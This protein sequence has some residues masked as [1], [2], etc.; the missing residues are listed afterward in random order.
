M[1]DLK[2]K[3]DYVDIN[4]ISGY[5]NNSRTHSEEQIR[6]IENS[7]KEFGMCNPIGVCNGVIVFGHGRYKA[8]GNL[9]YDEIPVIDLSHLNGEQMKALVIA[10]NKIGDNSSFDYDILKIE[11]EELADADFDLSLTGFNDIEIESMLGENEFEEPELNDL[12][13]AKENYDNAEVKR[14]VLMYSAEDFDDISERAEKLVEELGVGDNSQLFQFLVESY[15][16][17]ACDE[18]DKT[19]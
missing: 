16:G 3:I 9:S 5:E 1:K 4:S 18:N 12:G 14:I 10:D 13:G 7:I 6:Q 8:L 11:L 19:E 2:L 15:K 17:E